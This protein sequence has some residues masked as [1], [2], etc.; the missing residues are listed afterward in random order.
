[1]TEKTILQLGN[2]RKRLNQ[3]L[4]FFKS[5]ENEVYRLFKIGKTRYSNVSLSYTLADSTFQI[6]DNKALEEYAYIFKAS[7]N[8]EGPTINITLVESKTNKVVS[9]KNSS[10][11][12]DSRFNVGKEYMSLTKYNNIRTSKNDKSKVISKSSKPTDNENNYNTK[13]KNKAINH[14]LSTN[15]TID[16]DSSK[17]EISDEL[18]TVVKKFEF[19]SNKAKNSPESDSLLKRINELRL[20]NK[21]TECCPLIAE[22]INTNPFNPEY[23]HLKAK[24]QIDLKDYDSAIFQLLTIKTFS[25]DYTLHMF[26]LAKCYFL[27]KDFAKCEELIFTLMKKDKNNED[28]YYLGYKLW[29]CRNKFTNASHT[30]NVLLYEDENNLGYMYENA[31]LY[32]KMDGYTVALSILEDLIKL[33]PNDPKYY[34][35]KFKCLIRLGRM[36]SAKSVLEHICSKFPT[37]DKGIE[38]YNYF[39]QCLSFNNHYEVDDASEFHDF[40]PLSRCNK[41]SKDRL[42]SRKRKKVNDDNTIKN[43]NTILNGSMTITCQNNE[44]EKIANIERQEDDHEYIKLKS[45]IYRCDDFCLLKRDYNEIIDIEDLLKSDVEVREMD[46]VI[47]EELISD[48]P[49][50]NLTFKYDNPIYNYCMDNIKPFKVQDILGYW[51]D[52]DEIFAYCQTYKRKSFKLKDITKIEGHFFCNGE[53]YYTILPK[54][55]DQLVYLRL[56]DCFSHDIFKLIRDYLLIDVSNKTG[57]I[58]EYTKFMEINKFYKIFKCKLNTEVTIYD[59]MNR[60]C[61]NRKNE[62]SNKSSILYDFEMDEIKEYFYTRDYKSGVTFVRCKKIFNFDLSTIDKYLSHEIKDSIMIQINNNQVSFVRTDWSMDLKLIE[63]EY[64]RMSKPKQKKRR[65]E[66]RYDR[67]KNEN[68]C[69]LFALMGISDKFTIKHNANTFRNKPLSV[70]INL[71]NKILIEDGLA[72]NRK[73]IS[74]ETLKDKLKTVIGKSILI[75]YNSEIDVHS[76]A[77]IYG[78]FT[79]YSQDVIQDYMDATLTILEMKI[80]DA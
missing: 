63:D 66:L 70:Q 17:E 52:L 76:E 5:L 57:N 40:I 14:N 68:N 3:E 60:N 22:L 26:D 78:K 58:A 59:L 51:D 4:I 64:N 56:F 46:N 21:Y 35:L 24:N 61:T 77:V 62:I 69:F 48:N 34:L 25:P 29:K 41:E 9:K 31:R 67:R 45:Q 30:M 19:N 47:N 11:N 55:Y 80:E 10:L 18:K 79:Q 42:L 49:N 23:L 13:P 8:N 74:I 72:L 39:S 53:L 15:D 33:D 50:C 71:A 37:F 1:M 32:F 75:M 38:E 43:T 28:V 27:K 36:T 20:E 54:K 44:L 7:P 73:L 16:Q 6:K 2:K 12:K 65:D